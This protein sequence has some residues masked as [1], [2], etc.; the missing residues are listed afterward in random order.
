MGKQ[1]Q[2]PTYNAV[3]KYSLGGRLQFKNVA[4][5]KVLID[6]VTFDQRPE[7]SWGLWM[8]GVGVGAEG[9]AP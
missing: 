2:Y 1:I 9:K 8:S 6:K 3:K 7:G 5:G 4:S